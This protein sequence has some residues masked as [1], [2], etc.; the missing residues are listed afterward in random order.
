MVQL[1]TVLPAGER[2]QLANI[3]GDHA[4]LLATPNRI[5]ADI[6]HP[7]ELKAL[8]IQVSQPPNPVVQDLMEYQIAGRSAGE[9]CT[10]C[11][12]VGEDKP[13]LIFPVCR[14]AKGEPGA[15]GECWFRHRASECSLSMPVSLL[16]SI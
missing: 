11:S 5:T 7:Q 2:P 1:R 3:Y 8:A 12:Q 10:R 14:R 13:D 4:V 16:D 9:R 6:T 15:C